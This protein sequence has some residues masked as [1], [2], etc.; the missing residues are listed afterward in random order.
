MG[1]PVWTYR[2]GYLAST[3]AS[4]G[5]TRG[6]VSE[7]GEGCL[8]F[9]GRR[10]HP[11]PHGGMHRAGNWRGRIFFCDMHETGV[12]EYVNEGRMPFEAE[13]EVGEKVG[14]EEYVDRITEEMHQ[15]VEHQ[16]CVFKQVLAGGASPADRQAYCP[17]V[18]REGVFRLPAAVPGN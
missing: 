3:P 17:F 4:A 11:E 13:M 10:P 14:I 7:R 12:H 6:E 18:D 16:R 15:R 2:L 5:A 9:P 1:L 8:L